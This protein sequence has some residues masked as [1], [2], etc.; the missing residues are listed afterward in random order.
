M[1]GF[2]GIS[3]KLEQRQQCNEIEV[4]K[5]VNQQYALKEYIHANYDVK[6]SLRLTRLEAAFCVRG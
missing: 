4:S 2:C 3:Q 1:K 6:I 5:I